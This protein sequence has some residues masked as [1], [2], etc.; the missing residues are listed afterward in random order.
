MRV[1]PDPKGVHF[2]RIQQEIAFVTYMADVE[3][4]KYIAGPIS[5]KTTGDKLLKSGDLVIVVTPYAR[6]ESVGYFDK[7][8]MCDQKFIQT[9]G[10]WFAISHAA[11]RRFSEKHPEVAAKV[12]MWDEIHDSILKGAPLAEEDKA[13]MTDPKRFGVIHGDINISNYFY[14]PEE[15]T[16]FV[17]DWDQVQRGWYMF[18]LAQAIYFVFVTADTGDLFTGTGKFPDCD[19]DRCLSYIIEGYESVAGAGAIDRDELWRMIGLRNY[20]VETF[21]R[22]AIAQGNIPTGVDGFCRVMLEYY[23]KK[24]AGFY[25]KREEGAGAASE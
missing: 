9:I 25:D 15:E 6:G 1:T 4:I 14:L 2:G 19:P 20:F 3:Q 21:C 23:E 16:L 11:S 13:S 24:R 22:E 5:A 18:D 7:R 10:K 12:Q 17:F 8:W